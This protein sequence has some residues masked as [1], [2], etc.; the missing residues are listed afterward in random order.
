MDY[1]ANCGVWGTMF[2]V[3][4]IV[5]DNLLRLA[6]GEQIKA[7]LFILR[8]SGKAVTSE[9]IAAAV[10][11]TPVQA[12]EAVLFW[13][14]VNVLSPEGQASP[15]TVMTSPAQKVQPVP[16]TVI[17]SPAVNAAEKKVQTAPP[18][19]KTDHQPSVISQMM[20]ENPDISDVF[21]ITE[22]ILGKLNHAMQNSLIWM[23]SY[24]GLK[25]EVIVTLVNYHAMIGKTSVDKIE[26]TA[27]RWAK[28]EINSLAA[29]QDEVERMNAQ[30]SFTGEIKRMFEM[31]HAPTTKQQEFIESWQRAGYS[32]PLIHLAYE[33]T[34][35]QINKLSFDYINSI[36]VS[37]SKSNYKTPDDVKAGEE[38]F[39]KGRK[40]DSKGNSDGFDP[41][42]YKAFINNI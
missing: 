2:G 4:C 7:L 5:A 6:S 10:G 28:M 11:I 29:A 34:L 18:P 3:P 39:R 20:R 22:Q 31:N 33:R 24:L 1:K 27:E 15:Q 38:E 8:N 40:S 30:N 35:E 23:Y 14:Q 19:K 12:E 42:K 26:R 36:L 37:W 16:Q 32:T 25:Q 17:A 21:K 41:E 9:E 13:Q